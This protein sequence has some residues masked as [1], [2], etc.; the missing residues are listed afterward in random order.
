M[1]SNH[2]TTVQYQK[3][4]IAHWDNVAH[5]RDSWH[6]WGRFYHRRVEEIYRFLIDPSQRVLEIG[7]GTGRFACIASTRARRGRGLFP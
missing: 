5:K 3:S 6:G 7:C 1:N 2:E 4:H